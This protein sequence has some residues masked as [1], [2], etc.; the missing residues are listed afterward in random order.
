MYWCVPSASHTVSTLPIYSEASF[1]LKNWEVLKVFVCG[2][3]GSFH[4]SETFCRHAAGSGIFTA[5]KTTSI[6]MYRKRG[7]CHLA[8]ASSG[9]TVMGICQAP[10]IQPWHLQPCNLWFWIQEV[11]FCCWLRWLYKDE[12]NR[13]WFWLWEGGWQNHRP[14]EE[15]VGFTP[16]LCQPL[17]LIFTVMV[18]FASG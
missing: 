9:M 7:R 8:G 6:T 10:I 5:W 4:A 3:V 12:S 1:P 16:L 14:S 11:F 13:K 2:S 15:S 17:M 18:C